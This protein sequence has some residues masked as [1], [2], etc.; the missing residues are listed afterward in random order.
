M[1]VGMGDSITDPFEAREVWEP[2]I[3][4]GG[5]QGK[6]RPVSRVDLGYRVRRAKMGAWD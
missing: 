2:N 6:I 1:P 4:Q 3:E 5:A